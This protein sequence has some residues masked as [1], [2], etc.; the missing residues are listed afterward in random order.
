MLWISYGVE[1]EVEIWRTRW[2]ESVMWEVKGV[3]GAGISEKQESCRWSKRGR[4]ACNEAMANKTEKK[5]KKLLCFLNMKSSKPSHKYSLRSYFALFKDLDQYFWESFHQSYIH[6][7]S[8]PASSS[9]L[10]FLLTSFFILVVGQHLHLLHLC[11]LSSPP[12]HLFPVACKATCQI[13][14][15][16]RQAKPLHFQNTQDW[17]ENPRSCVV[18]MLHLSKLPEDTVFLPNRHLTSAQLIQMAS[19]IPTLCWDWATQKS[20]TGKITSPSS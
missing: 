18:T 4:I 17:A 6:L 10:P 7:C 19:Q 8:Q 3:E 15:H 9:A 20:K 11:K 16:M 2:W 5:N 1:K 12:D 14:Y 13:S